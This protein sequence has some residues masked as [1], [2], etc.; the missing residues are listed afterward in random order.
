[1]ALGEDSSLRGVVRDVESGERLSRVTA[2]LAGEAREE[3][4]DANG[5]FDF[6]AVAAGEHVLKIATVGYRV[7][8]IRVTVG[9]APVEVEIALTPDAL[10]R[11]DRVEVRADPF[12]LASAAGPTEFSING[13]EAKNLTRPCWR[14]IPCARRRRS[15]G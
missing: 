8:Q 6:G 12:D 4:T 13:A 14:T 1:M 5:S 9:A 11:R 2:L 15:P 10:A 7:L 3:R